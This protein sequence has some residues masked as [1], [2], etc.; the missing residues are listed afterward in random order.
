MLMY[1]IMYF[2]LAFSIKYCILK[3]SK[4]DKK[5]HKLNLRSKTNILM[6]IINIFLFSKK[7]IKMK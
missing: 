7:I 1:I 4:N 3:S 6:L 2:M 5:V